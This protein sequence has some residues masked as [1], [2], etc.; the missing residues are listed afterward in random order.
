MSDIRRIRFVYKSI[1]VL[2]CGLWR[3]T[4]ETALV[5]EPDL[6]LRNGIIHI[7]DKVLIPPTAS[8]L[9]RLQEGN[10]SIFIGLLNQ[11]SPNLLKL[12]GDS[13]KTF[14]VFAPSD[15]ALNSTMPPGMLQRLVLDPEMLY[16]VAARHILPA[17]VV[18]ST[19]EL[20]LTYSYKA[21]SEEL[22]TITKEN[23]D[24]LT[25]ARL[26][27]VL[28]GDVL[29]TNGVLHEISRMIQF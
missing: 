14:T 1:M 22:I 20:H 26:A 23:S 27:E 16:K 11:T 3:V 17:F 12:L 2:L 29:A 7:I 8:I 18:S 19:L 6:Q 13:T 24:A 25:V 10:F 21:V 9:D 15:E 5:I 4:V 28:S